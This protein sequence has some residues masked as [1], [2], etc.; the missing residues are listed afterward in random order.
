[1]ANEQP[2]TPNRQQMIDDIYTSESN[3]SA[4][5]EEDDAHWTMRR[6]ELLDIETLNVIWEA[7]T[8]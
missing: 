3:W 4:A 2:T 6:L 7:V 1:M 8:S 5:M